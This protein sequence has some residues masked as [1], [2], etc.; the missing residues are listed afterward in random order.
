M[1]T[2]P[3][4]PNFLNHL[5]GVLR[6]LRIS[7][8]REELARRAEADD[9]DSSCLK[10][11]PPS[12]ATWRWATLQEVLLYLVPCMMILLQCWTFEIFKSAKQRALEISAR[13]SIMSD[14]FQVRFKTVRDLMSELHSIRVWGSGCDCHEEQRKQGKHV[15]Y[16]NRQ[17][18]RLPKVVVRVAQFLARCSRAGEYPLQGHALFCEPI[19]KALEEERSFA[20]THAAAIASTHCRHYAEQPSNLAAVETVQDL[21]AALLLWLATP[22]KRRHKFCSYMFDPASPCGA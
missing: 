10:K 5:R 1:E 8:Y 20:F 16:C 7:T 4:W 9:L 2:L 14:A 18:K 3:W 19:S 6:F 17:G 13:A 15:G 12:L 22:L 11:S 21:E